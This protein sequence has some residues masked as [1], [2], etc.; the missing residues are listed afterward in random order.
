M[1]GEVVKLRE[2][3]AALK[4]Q[5]SKHY[6]EQ[7]EAMNQLG[8]LRQKLETTRSCL[9]DAETRN[10][11]LTENRASG[12]IAGS[13]IQQILEM[14]KQHLKEKQR[15][16]AAFNQNNASL[17]SVQISEANSSLKSDDMS[18]LRYFVNSD[19]SYVTEPIFIYLLV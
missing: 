12:Q 11:Q 4:E 17:T 7:I 2:S 15:L 3:N 18:N 16:L 6:S 5:T 19:V 9:R 10:E 1:A 14:D 13:A 8:N